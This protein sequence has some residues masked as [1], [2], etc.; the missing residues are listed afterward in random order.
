MFSAK[1]V[2]Q[3]NTGTGAPL[4]INQTFTWASVQTISVHYSSDAI[5]ISSFVMY[6][7]GMTATSR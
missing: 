5:R 3:A 1:V 7:L 6:V 4:P 2:M